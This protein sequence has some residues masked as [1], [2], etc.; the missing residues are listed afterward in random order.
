MS[1]KV[2]F[3]EKAVAQPLL[4]GRGYSAA[5]S[6]RLFGFHMQISLYSK[7]VRLIFEDIILHVLKQ[8]TETT[9]P[10]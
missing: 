4:P 9:I 2:V 1:I 8:L 7:P 3:R 5:Q 6:R 10:R